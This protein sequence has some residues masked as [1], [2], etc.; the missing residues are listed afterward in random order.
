MAIIA[1]MPG[2]YHRDVA[3]ARAQQGQCVDHHA[4]VLVDPELVGK[5]EERS[6]DTIGRP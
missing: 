4:V 1:G 6:L 2:A 3:T 5:M